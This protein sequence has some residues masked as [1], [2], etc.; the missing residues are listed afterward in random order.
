VSKFFR[1]LKR[2]AGCEHLLVNEWS[3]QRRHVH[4]LAR[5]EAALTSA[6]IGELW[7]SVSPLPST[8]Y[9]AKVRSPPA[10]ARY[11]AKHIRGGGEL[12]PAAFGGRLVTYSRRFFVRPRAKLWNELKAEWHDKRGGRQ[13]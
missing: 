11:V 8:W 12:P 1:K 4:V 9:C 13:I 3:H 6:L 7:G 2:R 5:T 10:V